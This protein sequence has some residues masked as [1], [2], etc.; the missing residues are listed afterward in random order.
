MNALSRE[1]ALPSRGS[2]SVTEEKLA[3]PVGPDW[4]VWLLKHEPVRY[5][6]S[7]RPLPSTSMRAATPVDLLPLNPI[8]PPH[9]K[10]LDPANGLKPMYRCPPALCCTDPPRMLG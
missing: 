4:L 9:E 10:V 2:E 8:F 6:L 7:G 1:T 5:T 3:V